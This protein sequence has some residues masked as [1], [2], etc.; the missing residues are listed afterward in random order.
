MTELNGDIISFA[1]KK[2]V[3]CSYFVTKKNTFL[4]QEGCV[5]LRP[6]G[7]RYSQTDSHRFENSTFS[8]VFMASL[9]LK[10]L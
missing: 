3:G 4:A 2:E 8:R 7:Q 10:L 5:N 6:A 9:A 1:I